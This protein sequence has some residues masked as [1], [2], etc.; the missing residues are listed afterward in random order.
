MCTNIISPSKGNTLSI[1]CFQCGSNETARQVPV[2]NNAGQLIGWLF[3]CD[4][5]YISQVI[6]NVLDV[7]VNIINTETIGQYVI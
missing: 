3:V 7:K 1:T 2:R 5:C 4:D 6:G